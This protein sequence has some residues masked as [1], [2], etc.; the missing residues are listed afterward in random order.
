MSQVFFN[1]VEEKNYQ[2]KYKGCKIK[3]ISTDMYFQ[4]TAVLVYPDGHT[5]KLYGIYALGV[6]ISWWKATRVAENGFQCGDY[7]QVCGSWQ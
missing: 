6:P 1:Q 3:H 5:E 2:G 4:K 7:V